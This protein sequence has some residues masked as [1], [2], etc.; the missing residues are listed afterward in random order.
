MIRQALAVNM[1]YLRQKLGLSQVDLAVRV[2]VD[3][4]S[5]SAI[6][7][8]RRFPRPETLEAIADVLG[9]TPAELI[10]NKGV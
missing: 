1:R 8:E 7:T 10:T 3:E 5:I 6:E 4:R 2:G 9:V